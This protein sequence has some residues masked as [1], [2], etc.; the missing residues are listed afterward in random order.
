MSEE[1]DD[2][3]WS[4]AHTREQHSA[5]GACREWTES[6]DGDTPPCGCPGFEL[7][8]GPNPGTRPSAD[9]HYRVC[10]LCG[11]IEDG[12][13]TCWACVDR[14]AWAK[15]HPWHRALMRHLRGKPPAPPIDAPD[16]MRFAAR[17]AVSHNL[18]PTRRP[19]A[20][21]QLRVSQGD[22]IRA[23]GNALCATCGLPLV[24]HATVRGYEWLHYRCDGV[25]VKT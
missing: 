23:A 17:L 20:P 4:C 7:D 10:N 1:D 11:A 21:D 14:W 24:E 19:F 2:P 6:G 15:D 8:A 22:Y 16:V 25:L 13:A 5:T 12:N 9:K 18:G 3:C